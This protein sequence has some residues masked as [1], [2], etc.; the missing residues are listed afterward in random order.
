MRVDYINAE[1]AVDGRRELRE[2]AGVRRRT[3]A[4][5]I[6]RLQRSSGG[7]AAVMHEHALHAIR[8]LVEREPHAGELFEERAL[9]RAAVAR[10]RTDDR[11]AALEAR[12]P[13][14]LRRRRA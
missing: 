3:P 14:A 7:A 12:R 4:G 13:A 11:P 8:V 10:D 6:H 9:A 5:R 2:E 1:R